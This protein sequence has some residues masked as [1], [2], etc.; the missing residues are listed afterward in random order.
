MANRS[1]VSK[2]ALKFVF[3]ATAAAVGTLLAVS[4]AKKKGKM[5]KSG[6]KKLLKN[7]KLKFKASRDQLNK[8]QRGILRLFDKEEKITNEMIGNVITGVTERTIR[9]D[10]NYLEARG[11]IKKIGK[12]KGSYYV[13]K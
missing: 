2:K 3:F 6:G 12:T 8:R 9:R 5:I 4:A 7:A 1:S 10:L 11:Y 13:L